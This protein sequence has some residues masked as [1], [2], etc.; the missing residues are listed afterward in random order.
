MEKYQS[1]AYQA[2]CQFFPNSCYTIQI[3]PLG[4]GNI[5]ASFVFHHAGQTFLLQKINPFVFPHPEQVIENIQIVFRH[6]QNKQPDL[7]LIELIPTQDGKW[8]WKDEEGAAWRLFPKIPHSYSTD[9]PPSPKMAHEGAQMVGR[10]L[11]A[12][13]GISTDR[14]HYTIPDFHNSLLRLDHFRQVVHLDNASR[15]ARVQKEVTFI[16]K[17]AH[18]FEQID[19]APLPKR[20][21]HNDAKM[22]NILFDSRTHR[23][24]GLIDWDTLMPGLILSDYGDMMRTFL[25]PLSEDSSQYDQIIIDPALFKTV[26][27]G[28]LQATSDLLEPMEKKLLPLAPLWITLEQT[29]R[30]LTD[31]LEGDVYY[32]INF[33]T[34]NLVRARNQMH[35]FKALEAITDALNT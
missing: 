6:L 27:A 17:N 25:N 3:Q 20:I 33:E 1:N 9:Y 32:K 31:F 8:F 30:F 16:E 23:A 34:H 12:L 28:F 19:S 26:Q 18:I 10:F 35:L 21:V 29:M 22:D 7:A 2:L 13:Q 15:L 5:N 14:L 11:A 4:K 24:L